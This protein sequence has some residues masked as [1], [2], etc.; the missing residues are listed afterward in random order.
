MSKL[1][2][3]SSSTAKTR[4]GY[5]LAGRTSDGVWIIKPSEPPTHFSS[6]QASAS[7]KKV[8]RESGLLRESA[9]GRFAENPKK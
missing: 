9:S 8:L 5:K 2:K 4:D 1:K 3:N 7:V 6:R